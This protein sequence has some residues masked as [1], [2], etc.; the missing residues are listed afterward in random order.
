MPMSPNWKVNLPMPKA[1]IT[2]INGFVGSHLADH[3][4]ASGYEVFGIDL[5][6]TLSQPNVYY[7]DI[8]N[9]KEIT[10]IL[11]Q[12]KPDH[13][14]HLAGSAF[15]PDAEAN[16]RSVYAINVMGTLNILETVRSLHLNTRI[17]VVSSGEVYGNVPKE[18]LPITE[19]YPL[20]P[21]SP[22]GVTK[23]CADLLAAQ[24]AT[25]YHMDVLRVRPFNHIGPRQSPQFVCSSLA[26]QLVEIESGL[27]SP[28]LQVGNLDAKR[29][30]TD[31]RD[32]V[33]AYRT[34]LEKGQS[35][36]VYNVGS[37]KMWKIN[38]LLHLLIEKSTATNISVQRQ[39]ER[40]RINDIPVLLADASKLTR[41]L[42]WT[43]QIPIQQSLSDLL[44]YWRVCIQEREISG[45][46]K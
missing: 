3:L 12:V 6:N 8:L 29:D 30:F 34:L 36:S 32:V 31:V 11:K 14:Y 15:V 33:C 4:L 24:Y 43:P 7:A 19:E 28:V 16:P 44:D 18:H 25:T 39:Q 40:T 17:L 37:G 9:A 45:A 2:G 46:Q 21:S 13:L 5:P 23:A 35:A 26:K 20:K 1:L 38:D 42:N 27:R 41:D 10:E 22:Y